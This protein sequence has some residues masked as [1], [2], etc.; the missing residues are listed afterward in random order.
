M[1]RGGP[2]E[3]LEKGS[4]RLEIAGSDAATCPRGQVRRLEK[5]GLRWTFSA[6]AGMGRLYGGV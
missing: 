2:A 5:H 1:L 3:P 4:D 6:W